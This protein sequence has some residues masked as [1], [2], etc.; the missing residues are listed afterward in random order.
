MAA[1]DQIRKIVGQ[2]YPKGRAFKMPYA[3]IFYRLNK[4]LAISEAAAHEAARSV[5][6]SVLPDNDNFTEDDALGWERRF[7]MVQYPDNNVPLDDRK[8]AIIRKWRHG[9]AAV[10]PRQNYRFIESQ[11]RLANFDVHVYENKFLT[12]PWTSYVTETPAEVLGAASGPIAVHDTATQHGEVQHGSGGYNKIVNYLEQDKDRAFI[13][14]AHL[15]NT[16]FIAGATVDTF[17]D[18]PIERQDEFR[19]LVLTIKPMHSVAYEFV[20]YV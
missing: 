10:K 20:N 8:A 19:Q 18:V 17:A 13:E 6:D 11:L 3:G 7:G 4:A 5:L 2:L 16:F 14:G 12:S 1:V 15:R 9:G